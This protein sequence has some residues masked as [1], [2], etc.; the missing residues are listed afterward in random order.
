MATRISND[1]CRKKKD[2]EIST[3][4]GRY[5]LNTPGPGVDMKYNSDPQIRLQKFGAN[6]MTNTIGI[7]NDLMCRTNMLSRDYLDIDNYKQ[8]HLNSKKIEYGAYCQASD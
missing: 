7:E 2:N 4:V 3:F 5:H 6:L 8:R 1:V